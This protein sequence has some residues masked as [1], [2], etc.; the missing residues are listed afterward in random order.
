[1]V[2]EGKPPE[3]SGPSN[4]WGPRLWHDDA[5]KLIDMTDSPPREHF[6]SFRE[7]LRDRQETEADAQDRVFGR[8]LTKGP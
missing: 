2:G 5:I 6:S 4:G 7:P 1:M 3:V 8:S